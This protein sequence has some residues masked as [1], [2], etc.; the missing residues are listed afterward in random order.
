MASSSMIYTFYIVCY[1]STTACVVYMY[2]LYVYKFNFNAI[3]LF[4]C[5]SHLSRTNIKQK[6]ILLFLDCFSQFFFC[7]CFAMMSKLLRP[8]QTIQILGR[9]SWFVIR[10]HFIQYP[11]NNSYNCLRTVHL[12]SCRCILVVFHFYLYCVFLC[13]FVYINQI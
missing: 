3:V 10:L 9:F 8:T 11:C 2:D 1:T 7:F 6:S 12:T 4:D 13:Y 5:V